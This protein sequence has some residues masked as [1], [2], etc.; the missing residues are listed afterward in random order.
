[1]DLELRSL[2]IS[3]QGQIDFSQHLL[4]VIC[5][6]LVPHVLGHRVYEPLERSQD[7]SS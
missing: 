5:I 4:L 2:E 3:S 7:Y 6:F 1:M